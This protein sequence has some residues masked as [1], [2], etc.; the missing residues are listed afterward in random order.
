MDFNFLENPYV[1]FLG[2]LPFLLPSILSKAANP[3]LTAS[4]TFS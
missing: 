3:F 4:F 1:I 2:F